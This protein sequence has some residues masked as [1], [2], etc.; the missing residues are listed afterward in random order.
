LGASIENVDKTLTHVLMPI[1]YVFHESLT[2]LFTVSV[3]HMK[4]NRIPIGLNPHGQIQNLAVFGVENKS[5]FHAGYFI[6]A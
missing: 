5:P 6:I 3:F 1:V 2:D 4:Q